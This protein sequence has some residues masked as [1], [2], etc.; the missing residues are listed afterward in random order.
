MNRQKAILILLLA[1]SLGTPGSLLGQRMSF[2]A[3]E[4]VG[5]SAEKLDLATD[6]LRSH[7]EQGNIA[8]VVAAVARDG[9][10]VYFDALRA[11]THSRQQ[12]IR[13][14]QWR[15]R[16]GGGQLGWAACLL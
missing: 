11:A 7:V 14:Q 9:Q 16:S 6:M 10:L 13:G 12:H 2:D 8:G 1:L 5:L 3:P 15:F 4:G